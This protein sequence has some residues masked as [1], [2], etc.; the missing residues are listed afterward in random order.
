MK[1]MFLK[2]RYKF[3][4]NMRTQDLNTHCNNTHN[5]TQNNKNDKVNKAFNLLGMWGVAA[6]S[7]FNPSFASK[8][9]VNI[10]NEFTK[11]KNTEQH[12]EQIVKS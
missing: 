1:Y 4:K 10:V 6:A 8:H 9:H 12:K 11:P 2:V 5:S 3:Y 7:T